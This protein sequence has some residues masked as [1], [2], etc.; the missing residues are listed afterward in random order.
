MRIIYFGSSRFSVP[1]LKS[2][3]SSVSCVVTRKGKPKGRG[4]LFEDN[5][6]KRAALEANLPLIEME[7]FKDEAVMHGIEAFRPELF[8]VASFGLIIPKWV[9][10]LPSIGPVNVHPSLLPVYRGPSPIQWVIRQGESRT[11]ITLIKM[12]E[13]MDAGNILYQE[14]EA[15]GEDDDAA[16]LSDRLSRRVGE[17]LPGFMENI[18]KHGLGAEMVQNH[19]EATYTPIITKEMGLIDWGRSPVEIS[20]QIRA[21]VV[22][23]TAYTFIDAQLLKIFKAEALAATDGGSHQVG[24]V[25]TLRR[26][27]FIVSSGKGTLL[28]KDV[29]VQSRKRMSGFD[30]ARGYRG[31]E[32]KVLG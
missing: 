15:I 20:R 25:L 9:L 16:S 29:Q 6:V 30:F 17:I 1:P 18:E 21:F 11:G 14:E 2:I 3:V 28:V 27:G 12:N 7:T 5:E 13:K 22:W 19:D 4:Y 10:D 26:D 8:L 23:P 32:G 24:T 31:L